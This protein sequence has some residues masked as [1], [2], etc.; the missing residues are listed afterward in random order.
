M[1]G[2]EVQADS[3][4]AEPLAVIWSDHAIQRVGERFGFNNKIRIPNEK[5]GLKGLEYGI[6]EEFEVHS[7]LVIYGCVRVDNGVLIRTVFRCGKKP[8][9]SESERDT[10]R[11]RL[12]RMN[13]MSRYHEDS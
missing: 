13:R 2:Q 5:I 10:R 11:N 4:E 1:K 7:G 12:M 9:P 8:M 3:V 6:K